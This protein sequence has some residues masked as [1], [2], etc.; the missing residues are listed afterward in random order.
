ME[1]ANVKIGREEHLSTFDGLPTTKKLQTLT[2]Q[3]RLNESSHRKVWERKQYY[4]REVIAEM[5][6]DGEK[7]EMFRSLRDKGYLI[8]IASNSIRENTRLM[9]H[10]VGLLP[11]CDWYYTNQDVVNP[12]PSPEMYLR[13]MLDANVGPEETIIVEDSHI[14]RKAALASGAHLCAVRDPDEVTLN[15][16]LDYI[17]RVGGGAKTQPKWQ[18]GNLNI[19]IP[20]AGRG[21]AF[22]RAG[23]TF[24]KPLVEINGKPMI[25]LVVE[26]LNIDAKHIFIVLKEHY[27]KYHM[28]QLLNLI[29]PNCEIIP[30][31][32]HTEGAACTTLMAK[33]LIDNDAPL[34]I[35]NS[36]QYLEWDSNEFMYSMLSDTVDGGIA[37][38]P[39]THPRWSFVELDEEGFVKRVA[40][41]EPISNHATCGVY[42]WSCGRDYVD[43]AEQMITKD[44]FSINGEF[45]VAPVYNELIE[46]GGKVKPYRVDAMWGLGTPE[47]LEVFL[48][49]V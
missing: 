41:K 47:D 26:N 29:A 30:I 16:I 17:E 5:S 38:F 27:E 35:A 8:A 7:V 25:Q 28:R 45:F 4:T 3:G 49:R 36:D 48:K 10:Y 19:L 40:E 22:V 33:E 39:S 20:M 21:G 1:V 37:I 12:K 34:L 9:L 6:I 13:C 42:Y 46:G 23:Y 18:G 14:G 24:P 11:W 32:S 15:R 2:E 43:C 31:E 44:V